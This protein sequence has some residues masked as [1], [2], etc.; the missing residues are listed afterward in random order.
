MNGL[1]E[2]SNK[3]DNSKTCP[4]AAAYLSK[5]A[6]SD[7]ELASGCACVCVRLFVCVDVVGGG[8]VY[9]WLVMSSR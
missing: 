2:G 3:K 9:I 1:I 5:V 7:S 6:C 8:G 4:S